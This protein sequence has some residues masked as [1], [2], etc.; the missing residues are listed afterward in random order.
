M[1]Y[2][3]LG[4]TD[5]VTPL[6]AAHFNHMEE[7]IEKANSVTETVGGDTLTWDGNTDGKATLENPEILGCFVKISDAIPVLSDCKNGM[8]V[9]TAGGVETIYSAGEIEE[10]YN[11]I[12]I[13]GSQ[14]GAYVIPSDGFVLMDT[15]TFPESGVWVAYVEGAPY[16][17]S[18]AIPGYTGFT[19]EI[20]KQDALPEALGFGDV[21]VELMPETEVTGTEDSGMYAV[22]LDISVITG[23]HEKLNVTFDGAEYSCGCTPIGEIGGVLYGNGSFFELDDTGEPFCIAVVPASFAMLAMQD[24]EAHMV[25]ISGM[26]VKKLDK[27]YLP[28]AALLYYDETYLYTDSDITDA[29][30]RITKE[31]LLLLFLSG[32]PI[33]IATAGNLWFAMV[34]NVDFGANY[35]YVVINTVTGNGGTPKNKLLYTAEYTPTT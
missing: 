18:I 3:K 9:Q 23:E 31:Q 27:K 8:I 7:G 28:D 30:K 34:L 13:V 5:G 25:A 26:G 15:F 6:D 19:K 11:A 32:R 35:G 33:R 24:A 1:T 4:F 29:S 14:L 10:F 2:E 17:S 20:I 16:V 22:N 21:V 12:G